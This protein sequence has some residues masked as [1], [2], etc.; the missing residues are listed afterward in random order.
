MAIT[1]TRS[2]TDIDRAVTQELRWDPRVDETGIAVSVK[3]GLVTLAGY[4]D[5]YA[6]KLA[7][8]EAAHRMEGVL[9][10]A[11]ELQVK[12]AGEA[13]NDVE[14]AKSVRQALVWDVFVPDECV[15]STVSGGWVKLEGE[16]DYASQRDDAVRAIERLR[17]VI[18]VTN[19][20]TIKAPRV[21][22][23][24]IQGSIETALARRAERGAKRIEV[25]VEGSTVKLSGAVDSWAE[26]RDV[27]HVASYSEGVAKVE[28]RIVINPYL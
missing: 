10:I 1:K 21:D 20:I 14:L 12:H 5:S 19:L 25:A 17:G 8:C 28:S 18:G 11:D 4:V 2:D 16:V 15:K 27:E 24:R 13:K 26:K 9:D 23:K 22:P 6:K 7:A 3:N